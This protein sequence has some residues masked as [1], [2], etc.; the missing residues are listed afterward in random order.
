MRWCKIAVSLS[1]TPCFQHVFDGI[2]KLEKAFSRHRQLPQFARLADGYLKRG[3]VLHALDLCREGCEDFPTYAA[4]HS[5]LSRCY[6]R[7][8]ELEKA[9]TALDRALRLDP[10]NPK[11]FFRLSR[12]YGEMGIA[13]LALKSIQQAAA[14]DPFSEEIAS[15]LELLHRE[16]PFSSSNA[17][18]PPVR[19]AEEEES[20]IHA[21]GDDFVDHQISSGATADV[22]R[23][24]PTQPGFEGGSETAPEVG[25]RTA[26]VELGE[27]S[28]DATPTDLETSSASGNAAGEAHSG[29]HTPGESPGAP[30]VSDDGASDDEPFGQVQ[31]L[32]EWGDQ[33]VPEAMEENDGL[34][35]HSSAQESDHELASLGEGLFGAEDFRAEDPLPAG[36]SPPADETEPSVPAES[37]T[38]ASKAES[39]PDLG[40]PAG[41]GEPSDPTG[42]A[43]VVDPEGP[44]PVEQ[45]I[46]LEKIN[47]LEGLSPL[48]EDPPP[49]D[50]PPPE[51]DSLPQKDLKS[52]EDLVP[53]EDPIPANLARPASERTDPTESMSVVSAE[54]VAPDGEDSGA[55]DAGNVD[56]SPDLNPPLHAE[57]KPTP[58]ASVSRISSGDDGK[59]LELFRQIELPDAEESDSGGGTGD[60]AQPPD[61][62]DLVEHTAAVASAE[63]RPLRRVADPPDA[64]PAPL[65][66]ADV[67]EPIATV[68]LA[69]LYAGQGFPDRA[70][71]TYRRILSDDPESEEIKSKLAELEQTLTTRTRVRP[72][73]RSSPPE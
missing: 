15:Q 59:L 48:E 6:E 26:I 70:A 53:R 41:G 31:P 19:E 5:V 55:V 69:E 72:L 39:P 18:D 35:S 40:R 33:P 34:S 64:S 25:A 13:T 68:T 63:Q 2:R 14:L 60:A 71:K 17:A 61:D 27:A 46:P 43:P 16:P 36:M 51:E 54:A 28:F 62:A 23:E 37:V 56:G 58:D 73:T 11:G 42:P 38:G 8:G 50:P 49:E 3:K 24:L 29:P 4:G 1:L 57:A 10:E 12:L 45:L 9:R 47:P 7:R 32:P 67:V 52:L 20:T 22:L 21:V 30:A 66:D 65:P 44:A